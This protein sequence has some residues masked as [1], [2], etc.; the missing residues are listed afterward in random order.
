MLTMATFSFAGKKA[1][2][3]V[4]LNVP[5]DA[6][7]KVTDD[8]RARAIVPTVNKILSDG[9]SAILMSHLGRPKGKVNPAMSLRPVA[10]HLSG[11]LGKPVHFA[12]DC[13]GPDATARAAALKPGEVL[14]LEN[15]RFHP[16]E[17]AGD[18]AFSKSLSE[19]GDVYVNDAFG[20]AHRAHASTTIVAKFFPTSKLF[21][22]LMQAEIDS[23]GKVLGTP[24]RPMT[25][26]VGGSKVSSKIDVLQ[27]L[28]G[29]CDEL[30]IGGGMANTF[31]KA[32]GGQTGA[33]LVEDDLLDTARRIIK[34]A[35]AKG[36]KLHIP[37]DAVV[38]DAFA[39]T[40]NT[41]QCAANAVPDGW[42][43]LD[44][45]P[46]S[47][48]AC[49]AAILR[50]KT[51]LWNGPMGVF[52]MKPFQQGTIAIAQAVADATSKGTFSLVGGGDSVAAVNQFG[53]ADKISY[54]STGGGAMLEYLE[55]KVLPGIAAVQG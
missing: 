43:A 42:M 31:V 25:A 19:L 6:T 48:E 1:L 14:V 15:L 10:A 51:L 45:G 23:V 4:D 38:A 33:S 27:N 30:I 46:K 39:E 18:E 16:E 50:S 32:M 24:Q 54:V 9:G 40:A 5:Q 3:R 34:D 12:I 8:T 35:E 17:E 29:T 11:L 13:V 21:G 26:I 28:I 47:I 7:G 36:V 44:I 49:R 20:T 37:T 52:E 2:V 53:L 55:G 22:Y 41:D